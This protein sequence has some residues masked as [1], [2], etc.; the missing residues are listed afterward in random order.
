M[1]VIATQAIAPKTQ[2]DL[3]QKTLLV[4]YFSRELSAISEQV[5][6]KAPV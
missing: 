3:G 6:T 1:Q 5:L 4:K 2:F